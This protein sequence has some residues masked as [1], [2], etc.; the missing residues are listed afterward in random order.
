MRLR[1][2]LAG[3]ICLVVILSSAGCFRITAN[4]LYSLPQASKE[5]L[6]LQEQIN[7][8]LAA[9]AEYAPPIAGPNRQP[10]QLRD[11]DGDG[12]NEAI[13][14]FRFTGDKPLRLYIMKQENGEYLPA[15]VIN[16]DGTAI[17]SIRYSDLDGDGVRELIVGWQMS[18]ALLHMTIY[19]I[20]GNRNAPLAGDDYNELNITDLNKDGNPDVIALRLQSTELPAQAAMF[21]LGPDGQVINHSARLSKGLESISHVQNG[22][23]SDG[24]PALF[25]EGGHSSGSVIS[26]IITFRSGGLCNITASISSGVSEETLRGYEVYCADVNGDGVMEVPFPRLLK[27]PSDAKY[28]VIDWFAYGKYGYRRE[29]FTTYHDFADGWYLILPAAWKKDISVRREDS[30]PGERALVF[31]RFGDSD[32]PPVDFLK[33]Y[34][35][36]GDDKGKRSEL[37]GRNILLEHRDTIYA[38]EILPAG[39]ENGVTMEVI[40]SSFRPL[41]WDWVTGDIS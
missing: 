7:A 11:L 26:D 6:K 36:S 2:A 27:S 21:S 16:G 3:L 1:K 20:K 41:N 32:V 28:Y 34:S 17:E 33:I 29:I 5:Y 31:C 25:I 15:N 23:L 39:A 22:L 38:A 37:P 19:S 35:I 12:V 40:K 18:A 4:E 9:G 13:A 8:V 14:F 24:T 30:V 10:V